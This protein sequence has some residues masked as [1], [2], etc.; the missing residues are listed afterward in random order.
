MAAGD[1]AGIKD[2]IE[3]EP[4]EEGDL[5]T[6]VKHLHLIGKILF[7]RSFVATQLIDPFGLWPLQ[8]P[9]DGM[10]GHIGKGLQEDRLESPKWRV[11]IIGIEVIFSIGEVLS[12]LCQ[13][14]GEAGVL[15]KVP[16]RDQQVDAANGRSIVSDGLEDAYVRDTPPVEGREQ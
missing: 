11:V 10:A 13:C 1:D 5:A 6:L 4:F 16:E 3:T 15:F 14:G 2:G 9:G 8:G 7:G 12:I